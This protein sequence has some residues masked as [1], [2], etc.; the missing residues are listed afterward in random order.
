MSRVVIFEY[1]H[2]VILESTPENT[3]LLRWLPEPYTVECAD[4]GL[5]CV[6]SS[7]VKV[8]VGFMEIGCSKCGELMSEKSFNVLS[9]FL[10]LVRTS[11]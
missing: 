11:K 2:W 1:E 8:A 4:G 9:G 5:L 3:D 10:K 7:G 6:P